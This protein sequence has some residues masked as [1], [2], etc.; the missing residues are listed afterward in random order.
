MHAITIGHHG[1]HDAA[2]AFGEAASGW[3]KS[4]EDSDDASWWSERRTAKGEEEAKKGRGRG[5]EEAKKRQGRGEGKP[6]TR[7]RT[8]EEEA[9][10]KREDFE[11]G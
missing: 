2:D 5:E 7:R 1:S 4:P 11:N 10:R 6:R 9:R 3:P 8:D